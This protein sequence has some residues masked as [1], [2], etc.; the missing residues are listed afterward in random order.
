MFQGAGTNKEDTLSFDDF[1]AQCGKKLKQSKAFKHAFLP[2][3]EPILRFQ[4][5][6]PICTRIFVG[7]TPYFMG[8]I[9]RSAGIVKT[10]RTVEHEP[11]KKGFYRDY[12]QKK[13]R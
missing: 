10:P 7:H 13:D 9:D 12:L 2:S 5:I 8:I 6:D 1:L 3:G 11:V 4:D